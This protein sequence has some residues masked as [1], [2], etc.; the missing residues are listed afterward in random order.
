[1]KRIVLLAQVLVL[2]FSA[3]GA[4]KAATT[5][6]T[7]RDR[8]WYV[9]QR[10]SHTGS[11]AEGLLMNV[12]MVNAIFEDRLR[13][14][15]D[16]EANSD[17]FIARIPEYVAQGVNAF[18]L[19]LQGGMPGYEGAQN[20]AFE[21]DGSLRPAYLARAE[22]VIRECDRQGVV[23]ILGLFYQRQSGVLRDEAAVRVGVVNAARWVRER[24]FENV[25]LE[26]ANEY[27]H[28]GFVHRLIRDPIGQASLIRLAKETAPGLLVS[29]SG[30]GDGRV[31]REVA[32][33][34]DFLL[35]HWN[36]TSVE[37][38][39][40]RIKE[41]KRFGKPV[42]CNEDDKT[43]AD[44]VA[45]LQ[46]SVD[47]GASYGLML[48]ELN[49]TFP[50]RFNGPADDPVFYVALRKLTMQREM[51]GQPKPDRPGLNREP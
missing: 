16:S 48:K 11:A 18:T 35:P 39:P 28:S 36:G 6:V 38:I 44:A 19:C 34:A 40:A 31:H 27:P 32:D 50:F 21:P 29:A 4:V 7:I 22:R 1:M 46:A 15:F 51:P 30:Y 45:A 49:Q 8:R 12:R 23:V 13:P 17:R 5:R 42:V 37:E 26:I 2:A 9:N 41:L 47:L 3:A 10:L 25:L 20:S 24:G 14:E 43:G 33:A